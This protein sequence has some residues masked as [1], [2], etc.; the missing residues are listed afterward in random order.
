MGF[1]HCPVKALKPR[2]ALDLLSAC[3]AAAKAEAGI[4]IQQPVK[5]GLEGLQAGPGRAKGHHVI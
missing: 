1:E 4:Q 3:Q 2:V 5:Q